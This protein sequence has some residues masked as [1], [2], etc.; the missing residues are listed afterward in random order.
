MRRITLILLGCLIC[1]QT[2]RAA[3]DSEPVIPL[4]N[5]ADQRTDPPKPSLGDFE[6]RVRALWEAIVTDQPQNAAPAFF[7]RD[8]FLLIKAI[9]Q[10]GRY[11]DQLQKRFEKDIHVLHGRTRDL[12]RAVFDHFELA[13]RGGFAKVGDEANRLPYWA[14][15]HSFIHYRVGGSLR[16]I[17]VRV[18][19]TWNDRWYVIHLNEF[20]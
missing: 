4:H 2:P 13:R 19:I 3:A 1:G 11:Y 14:S 16:R 20:K 12:D 6:Q 8:P 7:P 10:P 17:E 9:V 18:V 15:R 5:R